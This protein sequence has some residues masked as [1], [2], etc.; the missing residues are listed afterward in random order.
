M[1]SS[2][3]SSSDILTLSLICKQHFL[4]VSLYFSPPPSTTP[5]V[6]A[7]FSFFHQGEEGPRGRKGEVCRI[8]LCGIRYNPFCLILQHTEKPC[9]ACTAAIEDSQSQYLQAWG[10]LAP[11]AKMYITKAVFFFFL[12]SEGKHIW[13][14]K[15]LLYCPQNHK[16]WR[17]YGLLLLSLFVECNSE[18][19]FVVEVSEE[20]LWLI[21]KWIQW[22]DR[23][24]DFLLILKPHIFWLHQQCWVL[25]TLYWKMLRKLHGASSSH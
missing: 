16:L 21:S 15:H 9:Q 18:V 25:V 14:I 2:T 7:L 10:N 12:F 8:R 20:S 23:E 17:Y 19:W 11:W 4:T 5:P 13:N 6:P 24:I 22:L 1:R 3:D